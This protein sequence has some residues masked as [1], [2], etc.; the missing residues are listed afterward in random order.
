MQN[1]VAQTAM[2]THIN[3]FLGALLKPFSLSYGTYGYC[4]FSGVVKTGCL[5]KYLAVGIIKS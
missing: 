3:T 4:M 1:T 2:H 5:Y